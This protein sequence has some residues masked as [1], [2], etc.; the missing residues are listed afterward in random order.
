VTLS[1]ADPVIRENPANPR[2]VVSRVVLHDCSYR[3]S[4]ASVSQSEQPGGMSQGVAILF[5]SYAKP[6]A[7]IWARQSVCRACRACR[8]LALSRNF[9]EH[10]LTHSGESFDSEGLGQ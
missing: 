5:D 6:G 10:G 4:S 2:S 8:A 7:R 3:G 1:D 9:V